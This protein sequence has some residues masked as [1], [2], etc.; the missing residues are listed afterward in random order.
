MDGSDTAAAAQGMSG[1]KER[2]NS[3]TFLVQIRGARFG[4]SDPLLNCLH[5]FP[6]FFRE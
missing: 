4:E 3:P 6:P 2:S 1:G 5:D